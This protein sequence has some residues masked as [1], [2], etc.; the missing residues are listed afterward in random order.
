[1]MLLP[2]ILLCARSRRPYK[3]ARA[4]SRKAPVC[5][6]AGQVHR[7]NFPQSETMIGT[8]RIFNHQSRSLINSTSISINAKTISQFGL[9]SLS[10]FGPPA[11][12]QLQQPRLRLR[13]AVSGCGIDEND[14]LLI[15]HPAHHGPSK[16]HS[17]RDSHYSDQQRYHQLMLCVSVLYQERI[18][19]R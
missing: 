17:Q 10:P 13:K 11:F 3:I 14:H 9:A 18:Q 7:E 4:K 19:R 15:G 12:F 8:S 2:R 6:S 1:M 5:R 16:H